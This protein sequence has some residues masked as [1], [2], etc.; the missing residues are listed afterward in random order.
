MSRS[1]INLALF[2]LAFI[3]A[4]TVVI[5]FADSTNTNAEKLLHICQD[6]CKERGSMY[7]FF[8]NGDRYND[9]DMPVYKCICADD[10]SLPLRF[11]EKKL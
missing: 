3:L 9:K 1:I 5:S 11:K 10:A 4:G 7:Q 6:S 8:V 2:I